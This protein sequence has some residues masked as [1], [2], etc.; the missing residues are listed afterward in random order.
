MRGGGGGAEA[1]GGRG[2]G[3]AKGAASSIPGMSHFSSVGQAAAGSLLNSSDALA[4]SW[5]ALRLGTELGSAALHERGVRE[6]GRHGGLAGIPPT[7]AEVLQLA[8][9]VRPGMCLPPR[10]SFLYQAVQCTAAHNELWRGSDPDG[11]TCA[12][13]DAQIRSGWPGSPPPPP[14]ALLV[15]YT[16]MSRLYEAM[17]Q[18][19]ADKGVV[20]GT[21][22]HYLTAPEVVER[23]RAAE[24][25]TAALAA[26]EREVLADA[27]ADLTERRS[28]VGAELS[29]LLGHRRPVG[30][31]EAI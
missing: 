17:C 13:I 28:A 21:Q 11:E 30:G 10:G 19:E 12:R 2:G 8:R 9:S 1:G 31:E 20:F 16:A 29:K 4:Y 26:M 7:A 6:A 27:P 15:P 5:D 25:G 24:N 18:H 3:G 23:M 14:G 22:T